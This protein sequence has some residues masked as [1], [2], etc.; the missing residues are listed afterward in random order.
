MSYGQ[1]LLHERTA[2][3]VNAIAQAQR[4]VHLHVVLQHKRWCGR[5]VQDVQLGRHEFNLPGGEVGIN[6]LRT[7]WLYCPAYSD[8]V[9]RPQ[10][11]GF[12]VRF[13]RRIWL[14]DHLPQARTVT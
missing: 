9:F 3:V 11:A 4:L 5:R 8:N 7:P 1:P 6:R 2:Q 14:E 13:W 12:L 10:F